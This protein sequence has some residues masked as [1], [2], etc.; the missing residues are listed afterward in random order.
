M[1]ASCSH[2]WGWEGLDRE[3]IAAVMGCSR[4]TVCVASIAPGN[5]LQ[6]H[7]EH[8]VWTRNV[9][10]DPDIQKVDGHKARTSPKEAL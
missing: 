6:G 7:C 2:W 1:T 5:G 3:A 4:A 8:M 10:T 9:G